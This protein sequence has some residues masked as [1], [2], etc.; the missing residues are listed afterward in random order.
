MAR[1]DY[2]LDKPDPKD[3][4]LF[5]ELIRKALLAKRTITIGFL[6]LAE[7]IFDIHRK[8]LYRL[9]YKTFSSFCEEELGFSRQTVYVY[10]AIL[11]LVMTYPKYFSREQAVEY[12]HKKMRYITEG[13]NAIDRKIEDKKIREKKKLE[14]FNKINP[15][16]AST[17]IESFIESI[18]EEL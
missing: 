10:I 6:E 3:Q 5:D 15:Q 1:N 13:I 2:I 11:K 12:G 14:I 18:V 4:K 9:K 7:S 16:M 8:R 17:E